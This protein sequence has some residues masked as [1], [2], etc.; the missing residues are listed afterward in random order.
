MVKAAKK[1]KDQ[2]K[3]AET[4]ALAVKFESDL[5]KRH[6]K[7]MNYFGEE[8]EE[9]E[10]DLIEQQRLKD[11]EEKQRKMAKK[12]RKQNKKKEEEQE[13]ERQIAYDK[14]N[15]VSMRDV[16]LDIIN[17]QLDGLSLHVKEIQSDGNCLFRSVIDQLDTL[18]LRSM[19]SDP[20]GTHAT[21]RRLAVQNM[22]ANPD[23][24]SPYLD[25]EDMVAGFDSYCTKMELTPAWGGQLEL[26]AISRSLECELWVHSADAPIVKMGQE[27]AN[28]QKPP[29]QVSFH[30]H[31]F[32]LGEHY[33]SVVR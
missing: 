10:V 29:L 18:S 4:E 16:E 3:R 32:A 9:E 26:Q 21:I 23:N 33:N 30:K 5:E 8:E 12:L 20:G 2:S 6:R 31:Y 25:E 11:E 1:A 7:E 13:R 24:Y 19:L 15:A 27:F 22:R 17:K 28:Q 14:A